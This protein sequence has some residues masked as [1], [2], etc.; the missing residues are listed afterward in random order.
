MLSHRAMMAAAAPFGLV[1]RASANAA[2]ESITIPATAREN[3][4]AILIDLATDSTVTA[5]IPTN[6]TEV[7][8]MA[9]DIG[10]IGQSKIRVSTKILTSSDPNTSVTGMNGSGGFMAKVMLVFG[11]VIGSRTFN[12]VANSTFGTSNPA[13]QTCNASGGTAPLIVLGIAA[14]AHSPY[15]A[16]FS[17]ASPAFDATVASGS[18]LVVGYKIY[19]ESP[20]DHTIDMDDLGDLNL[21]ESAYI[22]CGAA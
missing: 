7:A 18:Y 22:E 14:D 6:W 9:D 10:G 17:T 21:L 8:S 1:F 4:L 3:D 20:Q 2:T 16:A 13:A 19:N 11:K 15:A 5:V 12:D